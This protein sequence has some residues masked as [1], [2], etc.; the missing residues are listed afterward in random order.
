MHRKATLKPNVLST[1]AVQNVLIE[2]LWQNH[3][4]RL[5]IIDVSSIYAMS[6]MKMA[7]RAISVFAQTTKSPDT[8]EW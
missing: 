7:M 2:P 6:T 1:S 3:Q 5:K 4:L 8:V